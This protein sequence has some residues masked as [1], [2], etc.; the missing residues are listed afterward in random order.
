MYGR[1]C[2]GGSLC[3]HYRYLC[4]KIAQ[5]PEGSPELRAGRSR[6][7]GGLWADLPPGRVTAY[8]SF[9][10]DLYAETDHCSQLTALPAGR[11]TCSVYFQPMN[12]LMKMTF[13]QN[14]KQ[15]GT[16]NTSKSKQEKK[17]C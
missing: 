2:E 15:R 1:V 7:W 14:R 4:A 10:G 6:G 17:K 13:A 11:L 16:W 8:Y 9:N 3:T 12:L 5:D